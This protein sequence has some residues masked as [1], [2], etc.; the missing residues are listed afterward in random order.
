MSLLLSVFNCH[1][2]L[3]TLY[4]CF[5]I[6]DNGGWFVCD[7]CGRRCDNDDETL[8]VLFVLTLV[9][10]FCVFI[11]VIIIVDVFFPLLLLLLVSFSI[12][13]FVFHLLLLLLFA[14]RYQCV[15]YVLRCPLY[16]WHHH[17]CNLA[18]TVIVV[19]YCWGVSQPEQIT[20]NV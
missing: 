6:G 5:V 15:T 1:C 16:L 18:V 12:F 10:S 11:F 4:R 13:V 7:S 2:H 17:C 19:L 14:S 3:E 8:V 9:F 20:L